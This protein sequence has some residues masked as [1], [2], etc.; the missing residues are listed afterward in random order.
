MLK[1]KIS[2]ITLA[3]SDLKASIDFYRRLGFEPYD[4]N[5]S[6]AFYKMGGVRFALYPK[7]KLLEEFPG[8]TFSNEPGGFTLAH[9]VA[10]KEKVD[11]VLKFV[12]EQGA[13]IIKPAEEVFWGGYS[14][15]FADPDGFLWEVAY[16]PFEDLS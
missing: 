11:E 5:E 13:R 16:N 2:I 15:Y 8:H 7:E 10:T 6:I 12:K 3:V 1:P 4:E 9:N 14:G